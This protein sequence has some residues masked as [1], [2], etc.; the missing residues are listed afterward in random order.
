MAESLQYLQRWSLLLSL[1][2]ATLLFTVFSQ[3]EP[4]ISTTGRLD[5]I[6]HTEF[7]ETMVPYALLDTVLCLKL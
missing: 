3:V 6:E 1:V 7:S 2:A 5:C 4:M